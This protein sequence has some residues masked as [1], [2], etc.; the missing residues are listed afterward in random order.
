MSEMKQERANELFQEVLDSLHFSLEYDERYGG[1]LVYDKE[2]N[3]YRGEEHHNNPD[4][5]NAAMAVCHTPMDV[6]E[7]LDGYVVSSFVDDMT[8]EL[9]SYGLKKQTDV[10]QTIGDIV[11][12][13]QE[14][15]NASEDTIE[16]RFYKDHAEEIAMMDLIANHISE[17]DLDTMYRSEQTKPVV[18]R[19]AENIMWD[20]DED[21]KRKLCTSYPMMIRC[22]ISRS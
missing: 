4:A 9:E 7:E 15:K 16:G 11:A 3:E 17:V 14:W 6:M 1:Y 2:T 12:M 18:K 20:V 10:P 5:E 8:D 21:A 13:V 22:V 19:V